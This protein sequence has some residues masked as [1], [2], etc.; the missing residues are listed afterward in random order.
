MPRLPKPYAHFQKKYPNLWAAYDKLGAAAHNAGPLDEKTRELIKLGIAIGARL[1]GAV[2]S[3][4]RKA[5]NAGATADEI[6]QAVFLA[7]PTVGFPTMMAALTWVEDV[8][9][10]KT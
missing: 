7:I 4:T 10:E 8:I 3:H 1:E 9:N 6:R 5:L 2:H